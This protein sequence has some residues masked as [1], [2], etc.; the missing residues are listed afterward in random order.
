MIASIEPTSAHYQSR[1]N[2][3]EPLLLTSRRG[4]QCFGGSSQAKTDELK[5]DFELEG[6]KEL[7]DRVQAIEMEG[8]QGRVQAFALK[9]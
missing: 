6:F 9:I 7:K 8:T 4:H 2:L 3:L 1:L 5:T